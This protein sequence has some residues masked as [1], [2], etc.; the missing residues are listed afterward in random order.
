[1]ACFEDVRRK[2]PRNL[3]CLG[4][5]SLSEGFM[6]GIIVS[7]YQVDEVM[8]ALGIT[9]I[10]TLGLTLFSLQTIIDFT[11]MV[12]ILWV[13]LLSLMM[14]GIFVWIFPKNNISNS[15]NIVCASIGA[16]IFG[17]YIIFDTQLMMG[18]KHR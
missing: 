6:I 3:A 8:M 18:G 16:F 13:A 14:F 9:V 10:L 11:A 12:G 15:K 1:M 17:V 2:S 4:I 7:C 5:F